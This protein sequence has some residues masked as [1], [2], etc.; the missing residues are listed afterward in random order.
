MTGDLVVVALFVTVA[1]LPMVAVAVVLVLYLVRSARPPRDPGLRVV[2]PGDLVVRAHVMR[3]GQDLSI[4]G[5]LSSELYGVLLVR[6]ADLVWQPEVGPGW[7]TPV[8]NVCVTAVHAALGFAS[9][10]VDVEIAGSGAWRL[11]VSDRPIN[12]IAR[13]DAKRHRQARVAVWFARQ[14]VARGAR[15]LRPGAAPTP[16]LPAPPSD[17]PTAPGG[18]S[19][20]EVGARILEHDR[21]RRRQ[22]VTWFT[23]ATVTGLALSALSVAASLR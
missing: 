10:S 11:E 15:D 9:P 8:G 16:P 3:P 13:N 5:N 17:V 2:T 14:L 23:A 6:G 19:V 1:A 22:L 12:R 7:Q 4:R 18:H 20:D 21:R